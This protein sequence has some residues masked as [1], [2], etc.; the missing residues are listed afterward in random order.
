MNRLK[1]NIDQKIKSLEALIGR[2][3]EQ[4]QTHLI[5]NLQGAIRELEYA[6]NKTLRKE[7]K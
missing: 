3:R 6:R 5:G 4:H 7:G 2:A 1:R